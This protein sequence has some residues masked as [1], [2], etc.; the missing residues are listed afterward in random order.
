MILYIWLFSQ[1][2]FLYFY[3][4]ISYNENKQCKVLFS[5]IYFLSIFVKNKIITDGLASLISDILFKKKPVLPISNPLEF[6]GINTMLWDCPPPPPR[7]HFESI[8]M[9][10]LR[11]IFIVEGE[12]RR[13]VN[14][15]NGMRVFGHKCSGTLPPTN[16]GGL[17]I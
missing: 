3:N 1:P 11:D 17:L 4:D 2:G 13:Q 6:S 14:K 7:S 10:L 15:T 16:G 8:K 9:N 12:V 5:K